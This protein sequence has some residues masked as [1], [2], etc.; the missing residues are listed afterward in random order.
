MNQTEDRKRSHAYVLTEAYMKQQLN[1]TSA[2][3][4]LFILTR[5]IIWIYNPVEFTEIIYSYMPYAHLW[6]SGDQPYLDQWYE[7]PP[8]TIPLFYLPHVIDMSTHDT[9]FHLNYANAYRGTLLLVDIGIFIMIWKTLK[10][11]TKHRA[12]FVG[13]LIYYIL[14]TTKAHDFIYDTMDLT[15]AAA[16]TLS[17]AAPILFKNKL[18]SFGTWLGFFLAFALKFVNAPLA[19]TYAVL[20]RRNIRRLLLSGCLAFL[21]VWGVPLAKYRTSLSVTLVYHQMRGLQVTS[22]P[23]VIASTIDHITDTETFVEKYKN[24]EITGPYSDR[25]KR[26]FDI[27]FIASIISFIGYTTKVAFFTKEEQAYS[28]RLHFT[29]G[30]VLLFMLVGK[31]QST[32]FLLWQIPLI[33]IYPF[34]S[35]KDQL[36]FTLASLAIIISSMTKIPNLPVGIFSVHLF[37]GWLRTGLFAFLFSRLLIKGIPAVSVI[38]KRNK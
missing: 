27:L 22:T 31:V 30:Y 38:H 7:Y 5:V 14:A 28:T 35:L 25:I 21:L 23:A 1:I 34:K 33:A 15:F 12:V 17:V 18:S 16:I 8:A 26:I 32:P 36:F 2:I 10:K 37:I 20:E 29:L 13:A 3:I 19:F 4:I 11:T 6:A 9:P 24:Y